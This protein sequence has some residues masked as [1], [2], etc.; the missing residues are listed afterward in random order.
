MSV[1]DQHIQEPP[2]EPYRFESGDLDFISEM[3]QPKQAM[4]ID[5]RPDFEPTNPEEHEE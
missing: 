3:E 2:Q 5:E 4:N 1:L